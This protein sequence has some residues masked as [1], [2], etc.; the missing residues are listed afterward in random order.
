M[1]EGS[2]PSVGKE[3]LA[4][5]SLGWGKKGIFGVDGVV[6]VGAEVVC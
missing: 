2:D 5:M 3:A 6:A 4:W 1:V